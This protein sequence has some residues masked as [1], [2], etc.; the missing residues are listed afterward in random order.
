MLIYINHNWLF[1]LEMHTSV[2]IC[3]PL[4]MTSSFLAIRIYLWWC[5]GVQ[6]VVHCIMHHYDGI[7]IALSL[8][9]MVPFSLE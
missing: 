1:K 7:V 4:C 3:P 9:K 5:L 8:S 6:A 2:L